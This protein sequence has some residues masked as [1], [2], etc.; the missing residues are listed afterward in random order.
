[1]LVNF[2]KTCISLSITGSEQIFTCQ[3]FNQVL[4]GDLP[5]FSFLLYCTQF[6]NTFCTSHVITLEAEV[7]R[8][9]LGLSLQQF[10]RPHGLYLIPFSTEPFNSSRTCDVPLLVSSQEKSIYFF[11]LKSRWPH[12]HDESIPSFSSRSLS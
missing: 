4:M 7:K 10:H 2:R 8:E 12:P 3:Y 5:Q 11:R 1:M 6:L 9:E